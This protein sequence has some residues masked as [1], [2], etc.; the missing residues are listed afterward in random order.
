MIPD[1]IPF[2]LRVGYRSTSKHCNLLVLTRFDY[3]QIKL[4]Y[5]DICTEIEEQL[6]P[7]NAEMYQLVDI[8]REQYESEQM[9]DD[10]DEQQQTHANVAGQ[11]RDGG[12]KP[13]RKKR[14]TRGRG[15]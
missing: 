3:A 15:R 6:R 10:R 8:D 5:R 1:D 4:L 14:G 7:E 2:N 13:K 9:G 11:K 12:S